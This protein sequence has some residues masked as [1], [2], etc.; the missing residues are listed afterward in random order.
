MSPEIACSLP[1][2][3]INDKELSP[4][5]KKQKHAWRF[6][7]GS[8]VEMSWD[9]YTPGI[10]NAIVV[11]TGWSWALLFVPACLHVL[12]L[13]CPQSVS[14]P[15]CHSTC[16]IWSAAAHLLCCQYA[17]AVEHPVWLADVLKVMVWHTPKGIIDEGGKVLEGYVNFNITLMAPPEDDR[18]AVSDCTANLLAWVLTAAALHHSRDL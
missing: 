9:P 15:V 5:K 8:A 3:Y 14:H 6:E 7:D 1:A 12:D 13:T 10:G 4:R 16:L 17:A 2:V 18:M 11:A